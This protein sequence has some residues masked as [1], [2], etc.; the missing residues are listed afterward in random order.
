MG[1]VSCQPI[2]LGKKPGYPMLIAG[3]TLPGAEPQRS[4]P[5]LADRLNHRLIR[6]NR[7]AWNAKTPVVEDAEATMSAHPETTLTVFEQRRH[8]FIRQPVS[9][10][11]AGKSSICETAK[12]RMP[13]PDP[14][15]ARAVLISC[16]GIA[17]DQ[18]LLCGVTVDQ[19][20]L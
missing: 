2:L 14:Q 15:G 3:Q 19:L 12:P 1:V 7:A 5:V 8:Q 4:L 13:C 10:G 20:L 6:K 17:V 16:V 9:H 18:A 11:I